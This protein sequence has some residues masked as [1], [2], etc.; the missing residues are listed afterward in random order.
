MENSVI[1]CDTSLVIEYLLAQGREPEAA[2]GSSPFLEPD[3]QREERE[4]WKT[5]FRYD[6]RFQFAIRLRSIVGWNFPNS[7]MVISPFVLLEL[8]EW[9]AEECFKQHALGGTHVK[10]IQ[11]HSRKEIGQ[12]IQAI[13]RDS[14]AND[15]SF[16]A[17]V[18]GAMAS[19]IRGE[20]LAG[21]QIR[22]VDQLKFAEDA[23]GK[24][25][26]LSHLQ[27]GMADIVHLLAADSLKCTHFATTDSDFH[28]LRKE[29]ENTFDFKVLFK[30]DIFGVVKPG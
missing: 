9:Y 4:Y 10:A 22:A 6:K 5:L 21:I 14:D 19:R 16:P 24:V 20:S 11:S 7:E 8:D 26:L 17:R 1:Y 13:V 30:D 23:F 27:L 18:W 15:N 2:N 25:S 28:R 29:I 3:H 12:F